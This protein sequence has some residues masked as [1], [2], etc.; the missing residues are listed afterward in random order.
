MEFNSPYL[1][2]QIIAYI[3][4]KRKLLPLIYKAIENA[5]ISP[6]ENIKFFDVFSGSGVV[7]RF[8]KFLG[9]EVYANDWEYYSYV[10]NQGFLNFNESDIEKI[11]GNRA[12]FE[13]L[14]NKINSLPVPGEENQYIAKYYAPKEFDVE[15]VDYKTERLFYTRENALAIDKIRNY[16]EENRSQESEKVFYLLLAILIYESATHTNT[17]G[18]FKAFHKEFGGHGKDALSR[19]MKKIELHFPVLIDSKAPVHVFQENANELA[20]KLK[21]I[22]I[23][24]LDP[25]YNQHQY[26]SNYHLLN[27]IA[28]WDKIPAPLDLNS[29]GI[30]KRKA[31]IREDWINT[32]SDYCYRD[33]AEKSFEDLIMNLDARF[34]FISY[35]TDGIIPFEKM[36]EICT[37]RG[38]LSLVTNEYT[39][40]RG[41]KQS[42]KRQ[43]TNIEFILSIDTSQKSDEESIREIDFIL[44]RK[45]TLLLFKQ[46]YSFEKLKEISDKIL[47]DEKKIIIEGIEIPTKD[48]FSLE[49]PEDFDNLDFERLERFYNKLSLGICETKEQELE[50]ILLRLEW[51]GA[52]N[53]SLIKQIPTVLNKLANKKNEQLFKIWF[54]KIE[55]LEQ[56]QPDLYHLIADKMQR[57]KEVAEI[58]MNVSR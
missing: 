51:N 53:R 39:T 44:K 13:S 17:S 25:P 31:A 3:G 12:E 20:R 38:K 57:I 45:K 21:G 7:A 8:A 47:E 58:R 52:D 10:L 4:N 2:E 43:N 30:L 37:K 6:A 16:I 54:S 5:G 27:T 24:Y 41:G 32:R 9:M 55:A 11:F 46:K 40:Y 18:V 50:E 26:G 14:L 19:I 49:I 48:F 34:I 23:A 42:N 28:K 33:S 15:Q 56:A 29:K 1:T 36:R 22:D 35:S